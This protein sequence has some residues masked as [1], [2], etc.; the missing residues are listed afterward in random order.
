MTNKSIIQVFDW[1]K[2][3]QLKTS[4][5]L[6]LGLP[7]ETPK[8]LLETIELTAKISPDFFAL[9][10]FYPYPGTKMYDFCQKNKYL[11]HKQPTNFVERFDTI[12]DMPNFLR[13][14]ILYYF[15]NFSKIL[16]TKKHSNSIFSKIN[17]S[18]LFNLL[19]IAPSS[20]YYKITQ[21]LLIIIRY[22]K[23]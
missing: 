23:K 2:K 9:S 12:L 11:K 3:I 22:A 15:N 7:E 4:A 10:I 14:D 1:A 8:E 21:L 18:I 16:E 20:N 13:T 17:K 5:Y 6:M 19:K